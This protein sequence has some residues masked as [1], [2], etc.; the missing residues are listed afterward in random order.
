[1]AAKGVSDGV[2]AVGKT[3]AEGVAAVGN[4]AVSGVNAVGDSIASA[5]DAE[6][7]ALSQDFVISLILLTTCCLETS[8]VQLVAR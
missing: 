3:A 8:S 6:E 5:A 2:G 7:Q 1:M 4:T